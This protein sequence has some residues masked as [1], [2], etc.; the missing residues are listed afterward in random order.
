MSLNSVQL[1]VKNTLDGM[2]LPLQLGNLTAYISPP[3]QSDG[4]EAGA[5][6]WGSRGDESRRATPRAQP[7]DLPSGAWKCAEHHLDIWL[8]WIGSIEDPNTDPREVDQQFPLIIDAVRAK[9]RNTPLLDYAGVLTD[10]VTGEVSH[11]L[12]LGEQISWD[13]APVRAVAD[14]RLRRYDAQLTC[15]AE[16]W[17]QA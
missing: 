15:S 9:L 13:Y 12:N 16:E 10:P 11:L 1:F 4:T 14:Q 6:V 7:N 2:L 5:Y 3:D 8:I 17:F